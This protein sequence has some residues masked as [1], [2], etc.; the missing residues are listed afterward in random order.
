MLGP[1]MCFF[2]DYLLTHP[3]VQMR[4]FSEK[5]CDPSIQVKHGAGSGLEV[6]A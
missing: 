3:H 4:L 6:C 5:F 1:S 2:P